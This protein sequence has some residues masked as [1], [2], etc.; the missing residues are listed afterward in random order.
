MLLFISNHR[1]KYNLEKCIRLI[2]YITWTSFVF[3]KKFNT[4]VISDKYN[5]QIKQIWTKWISKLQELVQ[6]SKFDHYLLTIIAPVNC[7]QLKLIYWNNFYVNII[8]LYTYLQ[9]LW[10]M[11]NIKHLRHSLT[12]LMWHLNCLYIRALMNELV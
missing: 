11:L 9:S 5:A 7:T 1:E 3:S 10:D 4:T 6:V 12:N 2:W 8:L